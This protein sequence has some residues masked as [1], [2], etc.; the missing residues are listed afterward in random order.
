MVSPSNQE[1]VQCRMIQVS[2]NKCWF[3]VGFAPIIIIINIILHMITKR[4]Q[5]LKTLVNASR[6]EDPVF[7]VV[8][9]Q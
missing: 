5:E 3:G 2:T 8:R 7:V 4:I 1:T 6:S 9:L